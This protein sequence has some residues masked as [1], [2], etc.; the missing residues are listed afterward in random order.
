[1]LDGSLSLISLVIIEEVKTPAKKE[2][3]LKKPLIILSQ[4]LLDY[5]IKE[6][7]KGIS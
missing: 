5:D 7:N 3:A 2:M 1:M 6:L 4:Y